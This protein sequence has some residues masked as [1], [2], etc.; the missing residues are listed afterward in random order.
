MITRWENIWTYEEIDTSNWG[1]INETSI[2]GH[3]AL[4]GLVKKDF[5]RIQEENE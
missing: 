3:I 1:I 4:D 2:T 5:K